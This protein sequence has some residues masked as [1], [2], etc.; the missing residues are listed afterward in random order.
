[1]ENMEDMEN[2]M[3]M[4]GAMEWTGSSQ[5]CRKKLSEAQ[6]NWNGVDPSWNSWKNV[7]TARWK[8]VHHTAV[9]FFQVSVCCCAGEYCKAVSQNLAEMLHGNAKTVECKENVHL[10]V[11]K[12][13]RRVFS[14]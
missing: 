4:N 13:R 7:E 14:N 5:Q 2:R 12:G 11:G 3:N 6:Y 8:K 10:S 9:I 1:M